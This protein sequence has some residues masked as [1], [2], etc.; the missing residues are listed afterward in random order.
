MASSAASAWLGWSSHSNAARAAFSRALFSSVP[1]SSARKPSRCNSQGRLVPWKS[2]LATITAAATTITKSRSGNG[3][4]SASRSGMA[5]AAASDKPPRMP[6]Q[7]TTTRS[8]VARPKSRAVAGPDSIHTSR[9]ANTTTTT[10][11]MTA[12]TRPAA[13]PCTQCSERQSS[14]PTKVNSTTLSRKTKT[15]R[16]AKACN[17]APGA[18]MRLRCEPT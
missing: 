7:A 1:K 6:A 17:R 5:S 10:A 13:M 14:M 15:S 4:P 16:K 3:F 9:D 8:P 12:T 2:R 11:D 18:K